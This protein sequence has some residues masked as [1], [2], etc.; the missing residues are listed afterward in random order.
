M[1]KK[2]DKLNF[3]LNSCLTSFFGESLF[4]NLSPKRKLE[5]QGKGIGLTNYQKN[6]RNYNKAEELY[7]D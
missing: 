7:E 3:S 6:A 4:I 2:L 5:C 1:K